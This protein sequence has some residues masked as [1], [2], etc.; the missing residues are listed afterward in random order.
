MS[1][2]QPGSPVD[3]QFQDEEATQRSP[4]GEKAVNGD[5]DSDEDDVQGGSRRRKAAP[6]AAEEEAEG[7]DLFGDEEEDGAEE[8]EKLTYVLAASVID[9]C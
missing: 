1:T 9:P 3:D 5:A 7:D 2:E 6:D 8:K 4:S